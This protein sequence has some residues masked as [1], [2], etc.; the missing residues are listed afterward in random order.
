MV[1]CHP[2]RTTATKNKEKI[3]LMKN[4][5]QQHIIYAGGELEE[6]PWNNNHTK[7]FL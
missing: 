6:K 3:N 4:E 7:S 2:S 5:R 1:S